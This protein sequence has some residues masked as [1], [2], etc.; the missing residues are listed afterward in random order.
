M[1]RTDKESKVTE[2][3]KEFIQ[4][5][6][7]VL[8]DYQGMNVAELTEMR[9]KLREVSVEFRIIKNTLS[10]IATNDTSITGLNPFLRG[11]TA[12]AISKKDSI[13]GIKILDKMVKEYPK[14]RYKV[15]VIEG[16]LVDK[17]DIPKYVDLPPREI[18]L[19]KLLGTAQAPVAGF[20]RVLSGT[21]TG[22]L[23]V[24]NGI[25]ESKSE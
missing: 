10:K 21:L 8:M 22:L 16:G 6:S 5:K 7:A 12:I 25:K 13:A 23:N 19:G 24:M 17:V 15:A 1:K 14:L 3:H 9:K 20:M 2:L 18:L 4:A 11:T